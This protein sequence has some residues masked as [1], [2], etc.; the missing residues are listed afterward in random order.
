M[1]AGDASP[2]STAFVTASVSRRGGGVATVVESLSRALAA[3]DGLDIRVFGLEDGSHGGDRQDWQGASATALR[4]LGPSAFGYAPDMTRTI[5][6]WDPMVV[7]TH[8]IWMHHSRSVLQW[9]RQTARPRIVSPHGMLDPWAIRNS[10]WKKRIAGALFEHRNLREADCLHALTESEARSMR[11]YGLDNPIA[12]IPNGTDLPDNVA[13][14]SD[15]SRDRPRRLLFIGRIHPKKGLIEL[16][17]AWALFRQAAPVAAG[18]WRLVIAGWDDGGHLANLRNEISSFGVADSIDLTG[19]VFGEAKDRLMREADAFVLPSYSEG[20]P[21]SVLEAWA[22]GLPVLMTRMCNLPVGFERGAA[23]EIDTRP[24][25]I[26]T[27]FVETLARE[28]IG[29]LGRRG[30]A[31]VEAEYSW[32]RVAAAHR[33]VYDWLCGRRERPQCVIMD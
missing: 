12:V 15:R 33:S 31:L 20:L 29:D 14:G 27:S 23:V 32:P 28:D 9:A 3:L 4:V 18:S 5:I 30:R 8:G 7:H 2:H 1:I 6:E 13:P 24:Q 16:I 17:Q 10:N 19:P 21:M 25:A 26:A 11:A 22:Y